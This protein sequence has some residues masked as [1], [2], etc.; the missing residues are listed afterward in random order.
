MTGSTQLKIFNSL[1]I[2]AL[3]VFAAVVLSSVSY[4]N[5]GDRASQ[6]IRLTDSYFS[7]LTTNP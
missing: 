4:S 5:G 2:I 6:K 1:G 3:L 7:S